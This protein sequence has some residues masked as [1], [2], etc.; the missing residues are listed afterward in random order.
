MRN[1]MLLGRL[2][3]LLSLTS[4]VSFGFMTLRDIGFWVRSARTDAELMRLRVCHESKAAF[5]HLYRTRPDPWAAAQS[6][7]SYQ[8]LK[9]RRILSMLP[10]RPYRSALDIGCGVGELTRQIAE[11]ADNVRGVDI[12]AAAVEHARLR[13]PEHRNIEFLQASMEDLPAAPSNTFDLVVIADV[14]Y[15]LRPLTEERF[16]ELLRLVT[17]QVQPGGTLLLTNHCF[18]RFDEMSRWVRQAH[19][20][21]GRWQGF[22][23]LRE[24]WHP[25]Y[26]TTVLAKF[27]DRKDSDKAGPTVHDEL[28]SPNNS[29]PWCR[30]RS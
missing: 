24:K 23:L 16:D 27:H 10:R 14:I 26:L 9:Y 2:G 19:A 1:G 28:L 21:V 13:S 18:F 5:D 6:H 30:E 7:Y 22:E 12:S 11:I 29:Q 15:Y 4:N 8:R 25:F 3:K 17:A 20:R